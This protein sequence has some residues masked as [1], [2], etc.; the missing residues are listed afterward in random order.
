MISNPTHRPDSCH[1]HCHDRGAATSNEPT[2]RCSLLRR[3]V[4]AS[5]TCFHFVAYVSHPAQPFNAIFYGAYESICTLMMKMQRL[6]SKDEL[7]PGFIFAAGGLAGSAGWCV[8]G[9]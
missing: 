4:A 7:H 2:L 3:T 8:V 6:E 9:S 1:Y 5:D